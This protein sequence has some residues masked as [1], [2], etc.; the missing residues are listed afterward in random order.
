MLRWLLGESQIGIKE[1]EL[2]KCNISLQHDKV[3][4]SC[5]DSSSHDTTDYV[6]QAVVVVQT[7]YSI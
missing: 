7:S 5:E 6:S 4:V 1:V 2:H 3:V